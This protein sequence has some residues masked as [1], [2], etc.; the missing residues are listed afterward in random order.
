MPWEEKERRRKM[1]DDLMHDIM[2]EINSA[3]LDQTVEVLVEDLHKGKWRGRTRTN[4]LVFFED[5]RDRRG[6]LAQVRITW[7]G[8]YSMQGVPA[9]APPKTPVLDMEN[10]LTP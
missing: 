6:D 5:E 1:L 4:K 8:P 9:D 3:Y 2:A 10:I 7:T